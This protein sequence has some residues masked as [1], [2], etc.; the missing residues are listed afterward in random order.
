MVLSP[1]FDSLPLHPRPRDLE[2]LSSYILRLAEV[3]DLSSLH[4][5]SAL[6]DIPTG[7]LTR[8]SDYPLLRFGMMTARASAKQEAILATTLYYFSTKFGRSTRPSPLAR[9]LKGSLGSHLRYCPVCLSENNYYRLTWRFLALPGCATHGCR[10]LDCCSHCGAALPLIGFPLKVGVCPACGGNLGHCRAEPLQEQESGEA[11]ER[12]LDLEYLLSPHSSEQEEVFSK[13][14]GR[15]LGVLRREKH[16]LAQ[17]VAVHLGVPESHIGGIERSSK[18]QGAPFWVYVKYADYLGVSL[19]DIFTNSSVKPGKQVEP[20]SLTTFITAS[21]QQPG[22]EQ[23]QRE[24]E[25]LKRLREA[26]PELKAQKKPITTKTVSEFVGLTPQ[27]IQHYSTAKVLWEQIRQ[28][29]HAEQK[30]SKQQLEEELLACVREAI[31]TLIANDCY[32]SQEAISKLVKMSSGGLRYYPRVRALIKESMVQQ[33]H[34]RSSH[35]QPTEAEVLKQVQ[36]AYTHL[37]VLKQSVTQQQ[38]SDILGLSLHRLRLYPQVRAILDQITEEG[39][40]LRQYQASSHELALAEQVRQAIQQLLA[41]KQ[42]LSRQAV[43][44][45]VGLTPRALARYPQIRPLLS[46]IS[47]IYKMNGPRRTKRRERELLEQ[48]RQIMKQLQEQ[49]LP[50]T[51][52]AVS[53]QLGLTTTALMYYPGFRKIYSRA[54]NKNRQEQHQKVRERE[55]ILVEQVQATIQHLRKNGIPLTLQNISKRVGISIAGLRRY[56]QIKELLQKVAEERRK[57]NQ[58]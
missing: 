22:T 34:L 24:A 41:Q 50:I 58:S 45:I 44:K 36:A 54:R 1:Y 25:L 48:V 33:Y 11:V 4:E 14:V 46:Q 32:P 17:N 23:N 20:L 9:F 40:R 30:I 16:L 43:G 13:A 29:I 3:N 42:P 56:S 10:L 51:Q 49:G 19:R 57:A 12:T 2:S 5:V 39:R 18:D 47:E 37:Q 15:N 35:N 55:A 26:I 28:E 6:L 38:I 21:N 8:L 53:I 52:K 7:T 31:A 27:G